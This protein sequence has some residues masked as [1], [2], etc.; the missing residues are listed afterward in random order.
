[1]SSQ[2]AAAYVPISKQCTEVKQYIVCKLV[3]MFTIHNTHGV[4]IYT[5]LLE[6]KMHKR[7]SKR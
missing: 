5:Y 3:F 1:L 4:Y 6:G 7:M 2:D